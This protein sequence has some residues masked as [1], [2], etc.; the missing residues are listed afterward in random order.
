MAAHITMPIREIRGPR[1]KNLSFESEFPRI[2][3]KK[4]FFIHAPH[5]I[6][7]KNEGPL[8]AKNR[9]SPGTRSFYEYHSLESQRTP[10]GRVKDIKKTLISFYRSFAFLSRFHLNFI[11]GAIV[12]PVQPKISLVWINFPFSSRR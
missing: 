1:R 7:R 8:Y 6:Y 10:T 11:P 2:F 12:Q 5:P 3:L 9:R 4:S